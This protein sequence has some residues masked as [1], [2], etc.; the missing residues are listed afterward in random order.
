[1][2]RF[3]LVGCGFVG[4]YFVRR[5]L[6]NR[7]QEDPEFKLIVMD[8]LRKAV[9]DKS[10]LTHDFRD[11]PNL[12][13]RWISAGDPWRLIDDFAQGIDAIIYT[14]AIADVPFAEKN[15][16][17]TMMTNCV[18]TLTFFEFLRTI[19]YQGLTILLSSE[20]SYGH[21]SKIP[22]KEDEAV[23]PEFANVYGMTKF[24]QEAIARTY[25]KAYGLRTVVLRSA[26]LYGAGSRPD[27]A[28][29]IFVKQCLSGTP[30]TLH[31]GRQSRDMNSVENMI[32]AITLV[33]E[34]GNDVVG[35]VFN[36]ASGTEYFFDELAKA[37]KYALKSDSLIEI[38]P[39]RAGESGLRVALDI[40]KARKKL[41]YEP[42][43]QLFP[44]GL[45]D[46]AEYV[47]FYDLMWSKEEVAR[48]RGVIGRDPKM[49]AQLM[50][51]E[52]AKEEKVEEEKNFL[53]QQAIKSKVAA[54]QFPPK[55]VEEEPP[56]QEE[57]TQEFP[58]KPE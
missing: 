35:E 42:K 50:R 2:K 3:L 40:S 22:I 15:P 43:V 53:I 39:Y 21:Q 46:V 7:P 47:A 19:N 11:N 17:A 32:D 58:P 49:A 5:M 33:L 54:Q 10:P 41:G 13:Y 31:G 28:I 8:S 56:K 29:P 9:F 45:A 55:P 48:L 51:E 27:Q 44:D 30:I 18:N 36:I 34:K 26:T 20:S 37:I 14:A 16:V 24:T 23:I 12:E 1:M 57:K 25:H 4:G 6:M 52:M 38:K